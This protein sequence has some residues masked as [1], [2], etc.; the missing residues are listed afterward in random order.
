MKTDHET[1]KE[2]AHILIQ[3]FSALEDR[4]ID[5]REGAQLCRAVVMIIAKV[6]PRLPK[7]WHRLLLDTA[8][9]VLKE[10]SDYLDGLEP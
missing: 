2:L 9:N 7:I 3:L 8:S 1:N 10:A 5:A 6:K 4:V